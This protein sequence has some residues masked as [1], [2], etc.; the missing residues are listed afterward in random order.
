MK[1][2]KFVSQEFH[3][4][5]LIELENLFHVSIWKFDGNIER[6]WY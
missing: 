5:V 1:E 4:N 6:Y 2:L 3:K